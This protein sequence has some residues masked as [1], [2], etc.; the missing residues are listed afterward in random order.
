MK[1]NELLIIFRFHLVKRNSMAMLLHF[2]GADGEG[3]EWS[4]VGSGSESES[5]RETGFTATHG[6]E[7]DSSWI[8]QLLVSFPSLSFF[9]H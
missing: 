8:P 6:Q 2:T 9:S 5:P 4:E 1:W 3:G 7:G